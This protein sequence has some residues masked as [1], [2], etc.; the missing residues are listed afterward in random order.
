MLLGWFISWVEL[1]VHDASLTT[2]PLTMTKKH[3]LEKKMVADKT[4]FTCNLL[5]QNCF[6]Q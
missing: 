4:I 3:F 1:F 2:Q 6:V 5:R